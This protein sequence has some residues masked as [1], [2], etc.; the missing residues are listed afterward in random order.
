MIPGTG[1]ASL[2]DE[3]SGHFQWPTG[4]EPSLSFETGFRVQLEIKVQGLGIKVFSC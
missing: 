2:A 4:Q 3:L 1:N